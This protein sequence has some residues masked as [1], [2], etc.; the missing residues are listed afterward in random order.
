ME[1]SFDEGNTGIHTQQRPLFAA[2]FP[3]EATAN[4]S[5]LAPQTPNSLKDSAA[6]L[7]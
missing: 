6:P 3:G 5:I 4:A 1:V 2:S 7:P